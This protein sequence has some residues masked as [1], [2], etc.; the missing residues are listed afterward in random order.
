[1]IRY[2]FLL[3][4]IISKGNKTRFMLTILA[5]LSMNVSSQEGFETIISTSTDLYVTQ[6]FCIDNGFLII[7]SRKTEN[8]LDG[9]IYK[10]DSYGQL[11]DSL[12]I[13]DG[14][15]N[16]FF[17]KAFFLDNGMIRT[18]SVKEKEDES[19]FY[20][21][22]T[23]DIDGNLSIYNELLYEDIEIG[24]FWSHIHNITLSNN[25]IYIVST[26]N[27]NPNLGPPYLDK[28]LLKMKQNGEIVFDSIYNESLLEMTMDFAQFP[29]SE[30]FILYCQPNFQGGNVLK[31]INIVD[32]NFNL[33]DSYFIEDYSPQ[34]SLRTINDSTIVIS[35]KESGDKMEPWYT[36]ISTYNLNFERINHI[37]TGNADSLS[38]PAFKNSI[39]IVE[40]N[41]Y[42]GSTFNLIPSD[43]PDA[44]SYFRLEK[45]DIN[46]NMLWQKYYGGDA[47]YELM[48]VRET[49]DS[50][51][52]LAGTRYE[53]GNSGPFE[54]DIFVLK[55]D[56]NGLITSTKEEPEI[57]IKNAIVTPNPGQNYMQL[58]TGIYPALLKVFNINGQVVLEEDIHQN[59]TTINTSS[60]KSGTFVWKLIKDGE[61]VETGKWV[62]D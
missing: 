47:Y 9:I 11:I 56:E 10:L 35:N 42:V 21:I 17:T 53:N 41:I 28:L 49:P 26:T 19:G 23:I 39:A 45:F 46:L 8:N 61:L 18:L 37:I 50:G 24:S 20:N 16:T 5:L 44:N 59:T 57:P 55:V 25:T 38:Y 14:I 62:K 48:D 33:I 32:T 30:N 40:N 2:L 43:Y 54:K 12:L 7:S 1:M 4:V 60:L 15:Y 36:A 51:V 29:G 27:G 13:E 3:E 58:H 34:A 22:K 31:P 6:S 52:I